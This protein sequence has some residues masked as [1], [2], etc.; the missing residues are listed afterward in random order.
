MR[1]WDDEKISKVGQAV[2]AA[3]A[4]VALFP[5]LYLVYQYSAKIS[6][7]SFTAMMIA[8]GALLFGAQFQ[9]RFKSAKPLRSFTHGRL[10]M[11]ADE[12]SR[13]KRMRSYAFD[14][15]VVGIGF[16]GFLA[17]GSWL[18]NRETFSEAQFLGMTGV[19]AWVAIAAIAIVAG[20]AVAY[21]MSVLI[22]E[23][24]AVDRRILAAELAERRAQATDAEREQA[25]REAWLSKSAEREVEW[26]EREAEWARREAELAA[27]EA[28]LAAREGTRAVKR[29]DA[30]PE[31]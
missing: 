22:G 19:G 14:A 9:R 29:E 1:D 13:A 26:E 8:I 23:G 27:R 10:P 17:L 12:A 20:G 4:F 24:S 2:Y 31:A 28:K 15:V 21:V 18:R 6:P 5:L 25:E 30:A 16:A 3:I 11:A 7:L